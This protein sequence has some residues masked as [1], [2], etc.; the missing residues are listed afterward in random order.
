MRARAAP[1]TEI[2]DVQAGRPRAVA[3]WGIPAFW[4]LFG[5][6]IAIHTYLS[7]LT[8]GHSFARILFFYVAVSLFWVPA[9]P[10]IAFLAR[11]CSLVPFRWPSAVAHLL[12][13]LAFASSSVAWHIWMLVALQPF[14]DMTITSFGPHYPHALWKWFPF[15][16][17]IYCGT[18][19]AVYALVFYERSKERSIRTAQLEREVAQARLDA[20]SLQLQPHF[21]FNAL[22][23]VTGLIRG[24]EDQAA[25][26]TV[27]GLSDMLRYA[28]DSSTAPEARLGE[29][30]EI[31]KRYL[32]I[33][34]LR[35]RERLKVMMDV[36]AGSTAA[37][38]PR[39]L[40]QP[41]VENAVRHGAAASA[42][43]SWLELKTRRAGDVLLIEVSNSAGAETA[44]ESGFGI[45]LQNTRARL[46][47]LYGASHRL[48]VRRLP[49]RFEL[50]LTLPW[51]ET[52][53]ER[54]GDD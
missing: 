28:L 41:L 20:L 40:L 17:L 32:A 6:F 31:V 36:D 12:A 34:G 16:L 8:H 2:L 29:E 53:A 39:L 43:A 1:A 26:S 27:A 30:I 51:Q 33:E 38:V 35:Y 5:G 4:T 24:E 14:D 7:M 37:R 42:G 23:T 46:D 21:L 15:E 10:A 3:V 54:R 52:I 45:G 25:I 13:A 9:T 48:S 22:H 44:S 18:V 49:D 47:Q 50:S 19:G 11:R